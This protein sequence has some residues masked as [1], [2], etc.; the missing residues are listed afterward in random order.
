LLQC[1]TFLGT[2]GQ[3][4]DRTSSS[5]GNS[6]SMQLTSMDQYLFNEFKG[7]HTSNASDYEAR[8]TDLAEHRS[9]A[10]CFS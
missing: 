9:R 10:Q 5:H 4:G 8:V 3:F 1:S 2:Q 6:P 7:H